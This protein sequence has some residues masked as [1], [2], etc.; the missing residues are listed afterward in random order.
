MNNVIVDM[1]PVRVQ[2]GL[3][4]SGRFSQALRTLD[5][6]LTCGFIEV[7]RLRA[8]EECLCP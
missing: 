7:K 2:I 6:M 4:C 5:I 3:G 1:Q 8:V